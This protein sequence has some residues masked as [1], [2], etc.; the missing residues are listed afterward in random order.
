MPRPWLS[1]LIAFLSGA[2]LFLPSGRAASSGGPADEC[3]ACHSPARNDLPSHPF[4]VT[5]QG[6]V[7]VDPIPLPLW[8]GTLTCQTCH[9]GHGPGTAERPFNLR[10]SPPDLCAACHRDGGGRWDRGHAPY[11]DTIHGGAR[12]AP[13]AGAPEA[14]PGGSVGDRCLVCHT[15]AEPGEGLP[16]P[17][18]AINSSI[19]HPMG[20][21]QAAAASGN[22]LRD[23]QLLTP[24][25][26]LHE[27]QVNCA[28][29]HRLFGGGR[30]LMAI[31][32]PRKQTC[33]GCHTFD[34]GEQLAAR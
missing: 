19:S 34:G 5:V 18:P 21:Y 22:G 28:T 2:F 6:K 33:L 23:E 29:C 3:L 9:L 1:C 8:D 17:P 15:N 12:L 25:L 13:L 11:A 27:G 24:A 26:R 32:G 20:P 31:K 7:A 10:L 14:R 16:I 30:Y 4:G